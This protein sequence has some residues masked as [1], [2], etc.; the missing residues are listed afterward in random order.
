MKSQYLA[1]NNEHATYIVSPHLGKIDMFIARGSLIDSIS[2]NY[3]LGVQLETSC[4]NRRQKQHGNV[5]KRYCPRSMFRKLIGFRTISQSST[6]K[7]VRP[8]NLILIQI[9]V[10][11]AYAR[12]K[13]ILI[14]KI[15]L[16]R[17]FRFI[18]RTIGK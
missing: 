16:L 7:I 6:M 18:T 5:F 1:A 4:G 10:L 15:R 9:S 17:R 13:H 14:T 8:T 2:N 11:N 12:E 3:S